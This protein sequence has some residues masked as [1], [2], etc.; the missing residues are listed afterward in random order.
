[1]RKLLLLLSL[2]LGINMMKADSFKVLFVNDASLKYVNGKQVKVGDIFSN[3]QDIQ[4]E[5]EKQAIKAINVVTKKQALFVG[6]SWIKKTGIDA[7]IYQQH[8]STHDDLDETAEPTLFD[9][10]SRTFDDHYD[11][12]DSI[13]VE[14]DVELSDKCYFQITYHY[15]DTQ[16]T[17]KLSHKDKNIIIDLALFNVDEEKLEPRDIVLNIDYIDEDG[18]TIFVKNVKVSYIPHQ[19]D[20]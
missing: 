13:L 3:V 8:L 9:K 14:A 4:W 1:M 15:G 19:L 6:K 17:K 20:K 10:L 11:L 16:L 18:K 12:L 5:K 7:L 2:A